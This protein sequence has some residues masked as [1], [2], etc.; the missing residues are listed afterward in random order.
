MVGDLLGDLAL[1]ALAVTLV[2]LGL[3]AVAVWRV[4]RRLRVSVRW[5]RG[6][7]TVQVWTSPPGPRRRAVALRREL[8]DAIAA[9]SHAVAVVAAAGGAVGDLP[10]LARRLARVAAPLDAELRILAREPDERELARLLPAARGRVEH[11]ERV[12]LTMRRAAGG[13]LGAHTE[14]QV[15]ALSATVE[16]EVS[17][18]SAGVDALLDLVAADP[19]AQARASAW[20][21]HSA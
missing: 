8:G 2:L 16:H 4:W 18:L 9:T 10:H 14:A 11:V 12:A 5:R 17:A 19:A 6:L 1:A 21:R 3:F 20:A 13:G 15:R 7:R